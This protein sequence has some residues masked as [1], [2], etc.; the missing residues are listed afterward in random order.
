MIMGIMAVLGSLFGCNKKDETGTDVNTNGD[1]AQVIELAEVDY[2]PGY[3]DM[4]GESHQNYL[5]FKDGTWTIRSLD[6][7]PGFREE[8]ETTYSVD[9]AAVAEF[10]AFINENDICDLA[11]RKENGD[12]ITDYTPWSFQLVFGERGNRQ[13]YRFM[14]YM[15][16]SE[17]DRELIK[18]LK[19]RFEAL[20]GKKN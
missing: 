19:I 11:D 3:N 12:F 16:Y 10:E 9:A 6:R 7:L 15:D 8:T 13:E 2:I 17:K 1:G 5:R 14:E 18:E 20:K 4:S